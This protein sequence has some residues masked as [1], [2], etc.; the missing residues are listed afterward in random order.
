LYSV[1]ISP[2]ATPG[3][4]GGLALLH[5]TEAPP[6]P[7]ENVRMAEKYLASQPWAAKAK[8]QIRTAEAFVYANEWEPVENDQAVRFRPFAMIYMPRDRPENEQPVTVVGESAYLKFANRFQVTDP[9]PGRII[10][11]ALQGNVRIVGPNGLTI[12]GR[13]FIYSEKAMR[14]WS[15]ESVHFAYGPH[16]GRGYGLQVELIADE[17]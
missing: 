10:G 15:D 4:Q 1:A 6:P 8:Y 12:V 2:F 7:P 16:R 3:D 13:N 11:G 9:D 17:S 14:L 5:S